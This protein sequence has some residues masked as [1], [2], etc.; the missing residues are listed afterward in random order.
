[1][2]SL[3][4][5]VVTGGAGFI[6]SH[7]AEFYARKGDRVTVIDNLSRAKLLGKKDERF[8]Y[9]WNYLRSLKNITLVKEDIRKPKKLERLIREADFIVHAAAQTTVTRS[10][11]DPRTDFES[12]AIGTF[13]VLE[14]ARKSR[15]NVAFAYCST[16]KVYGDNV[17]NVSVKEGKTRYTFQ[18][19]FERGINESFPIDLCEHTPYGCSKL[20]GDIYVQ[21]YSRLYGLNAAV[22]RLSCIYG[23][24]QFGIE[25]QGWLAWFAIATITEK[26]MT[27][28]G[29]GK[30]VR[31]VLYI[32][33]LVGAFDAFL[34][35]SKT[36][37]GEV[38]NIGG[39]PINTLSLL[40][41]I[42]LLEKLANKKIG[43]NY[44]GWRPSDQKVYIS[45]I[46]KAKEKLNWTPKVNPAV[47][48][49]KLV[50]WVQENRSLFQ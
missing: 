6:G 38:F 20:S 10:L 9:N 37:V 31:D 8:N 24:R 5:I 50:G 45:N 7:V 11:T 3:R 36:L 46:S 18:G 30:Q 39:G 14:A 27:I 47:G 41:L 23:T 19:K 42:R 17:N 44:S 2:S 29:D 26:P 40:E 34:K 33:D 43:L 35:R 15:R 49:R 1:M 28:Y 25:D 22:F 48:V 4:N 12:N 13:N 32:T 16:N 21:D